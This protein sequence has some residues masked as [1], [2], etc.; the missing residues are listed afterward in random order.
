MNNLSLQALELDG[1]NLCYRE[2]VVSRY[3][4][5]ITGSKTLIAKHLNLFTKSDVIEYFKWAGEII[6]VRFSSLD[7]GN[8]SGYC[9]IE[10]ENEEAAKRAAKCSGQQCLGRPFELGFAHETICV[11]GF[12]TTIK[13]DQI[14]SSLEELFSTC[15]K[16][17]WM[18]IPTF[19]HS[20][21]TLGKAF[22][23]FYDLRAFPKALALDGHILGGFTLRV[24]DA[25]PLELHVK[26]PGRRMKIG[27]RPVGPYSGSVYAHRYFPHRGWGGAGIGKP[28][29]LL[30]KSAGKKVVFDD[31]SPGGRT[32]DWVWVPK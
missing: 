14:H 9:H 4:T 2:I 13:F 23:E 17:L 16:I 27:A 29:G 1:Q 15:G 11:R 3:G 21:V 24:E 22:I 32:V 20:S 8:F 30:N 19:P 6:D 10:F 12:D 31:D 25:I 5:R 28:E 18:H 26:P 7:D